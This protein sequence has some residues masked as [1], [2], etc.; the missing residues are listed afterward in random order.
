MFLV[1]PRISGA[2]SGVR[3]VLTLRCPPVLEP[4]GGLA[5]ARFCGRFRI[6]PNWL[7][8]ATLRTWRQESASRRRAQGVAANATVSQVRGEMK[9]RKQDG[10]VRAAEAQRSYFINR[11]LIRRTASNRLSPA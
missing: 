7:R 4:P 9:A 5:Q 2:P 10:I 8:K 11:R 6:E 1:E 3:P